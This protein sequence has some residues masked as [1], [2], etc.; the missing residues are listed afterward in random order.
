MG[1][2]ERRQAE[3]IMLTPP[4]AGRLHDQ[5]VR[6]VDIGPRGTRLEHDEPLHASDPARLSFFWLGDEISLDCLVARSDAEPHRSPDGASIF[7]TGLEFR[8]PADGRLP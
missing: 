8:P 1:S 3:R 4:L 6:I 7:N 2:Q 5:D